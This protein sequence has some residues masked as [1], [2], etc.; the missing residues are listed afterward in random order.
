MAQISIAGDT[1]GT[2]T[3]AAPA[4]SGTTTLTLPTTSGTVLTSAASQTLTTPNVVGPLT[5]TSGGITFNANPGGGTQATL[6]DYEVGTW[7]PAVAFGGNSVGVTYTAN[8]GNYVKVGN[9]VHIQMY[10]YLSSKGSSTGVITFT[11]L[12]FAAKN[13]SNAYN[14]FSFYC[15]LS[16][17]TSGSF[18]A[19]ISPNTQYVNLTFSQTGTSANFT[20]T[21]CLNN[22]DFIISGTYI[23]NT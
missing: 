14:S 16:T 17:G 2:V 21:Q 10:S 20:N 11:G 4:V 8:V 22:S 7:T 15:G 6:S 13:Q 19:Y 3:L 9:V 5:L 18:M 1:S 12:P 23:S